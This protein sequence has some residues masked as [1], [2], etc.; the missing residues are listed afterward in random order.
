MSD[1]VRVY[2]PEGG[3]LLDATPH[4]IPGS[5][6]LRGEEWVGEA[7][8]LPSEFDKAVFATFLVLAPQE[9]TETRFLYE[10]P[11]GVVER[12]GDI[13]RYRLYIQ[14][15]GGTDC[16]EVLVAVNLPAGSS[17]VAAHPPPARYDGDVLL[18]SLELPTDVELSVEWE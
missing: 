2:T 3:R 18:Y 11:P 1:Y 16:N 5:I 6:L 13:W 15:Q 7:Q 8:V 9:W 4:R 12:N 14:K 10:L 17:E